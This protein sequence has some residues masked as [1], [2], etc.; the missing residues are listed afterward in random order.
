MFSIW[1][2]KT[3]ERSGCC[4]GKIRVKLYPNPVRLHGQLSLTLTSTDTRLTWHSGKWPWARNQSWHRLNSLKLFF[5]ATICGSMDNRH[6]QMAHS[7]DDLGEGSDVLYRIG[8][9]MRKWY[10]K[11]VS[12]PIYLGICHRM[13]LHTTTM[14]IRSMRN[15][16]SALIL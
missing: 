7:T 13:N 9:G 14:S 12:F 10:I 5:F 6:R 15:Y 16:Q 4:W 3:D 1:A 11:S 2:H 8:K